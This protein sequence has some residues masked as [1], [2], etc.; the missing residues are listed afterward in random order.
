MRDRRVGKHALN[1]GL[2]DRREVAYGHR[3]H[4]HDDEHFLPVGGDAYEPAHQHAQRDG[5]SGQL[6]RR[7]YHQSDSRRRTVVDIGN[8]H[9]KRHDAKLER[10]PGDDEHKTKNDHA[11]FRFARGYLTRDKGDVEIAGTAVDHRHAV[12]EQPGSERAEDEILDRRLGRDGR[13][14]VQRHHRVERQRQHFQTQVQGDEVG[15]G[16]HH[17]HSQE[18]EHRKDV[19]LP[20]EQAALGHVAARIDETCCH[21]DVGAQL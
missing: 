6:G 11:F 5:E 20:R 3:Q 2:R 15:G 13:I 18:R 14:A 7:P 10:Q 8:P 1:V 19:V 4:R 16:N 9:V 17:H 12:Q 21:G